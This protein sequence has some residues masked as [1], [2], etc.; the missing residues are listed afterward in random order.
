MKKILLIICVIVTSMGCFAA[1]SGGSNVPS[2]GSATEQL[3]ASFT[4]HN[5][6]TPIPT[7]TKAQMTQDILQLQ[8]DIETT[9]VNPW[10]FCTQTQF[11]TLVQN[12]IKQLKNGENA[13]DF[14]R[15]VAPLLHMMRC[16]HLAVLVFPENIS[17]SRIMDSQK[18]YCPIEMNITDNQRVLF[19]GVLYNNGYVKYKGFQIEAINGVAMTQI[20]N[21]VL[22]FSNSEQTQGEIYSMNQKLGLSIFTYYYN[23]YY[24]YSQNYSVT[25]SNERKKVTINIPSMSRQQFFNQLT[26]G[27]EQFKES[28]QYSFTILPNNIGYIKFPSC[29]EYD[30]NFSSFISSVAEQLNKKQCK[31]VIIDI[32]GNGGG[33]D[34][35]WQSMLEELTNKPFCEGNFQTKISPLW[36]SSQNYEYYGYSNQEDFFKNYN[37]KIGQIV[38]NSCLINRNFYPKALWNG[39]LYLL[40]DRGDFSSAIDFAGVF[41]DCKLGYIMGEPT[42]GTP[43]MQGSMITDTLKN[44]NLKIGI[45]TEVIFRPNGLPS[46]NQPVYPDYFSNN[47]L[48]DAQTMIANLQKMGI[49]E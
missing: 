4:Q 46:Y 30:S 19:Q 37:S 7:Y 18:S 6:K 12:T 2:S 45:P 20:V 1:T 34:S 38:N 13:L 21:N 9:M 29:V 24:G 15:Q 16:E 28:K 14:Y 40:T 31:S 47:A 17:I 23:L 8:N 44:T 33:G 36:I 3:V 5:D 11:E 22:K 10:V 42:G 32:R 35:G 39:N 48:Q 27:Y 49:N 41:K 25:L 26:L 43:E